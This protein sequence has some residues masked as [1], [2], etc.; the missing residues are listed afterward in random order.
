ML[1]SLELA[2]FKSFADK[3]RFEFPAGVTAVV[4]P[5]GSGKSN[6]VDAIKWVL[7]SQSPKSLRGKEMTDV[8]F[9]GSAG[10]RPLNSAEVT[11]EFENPEPPAGGRRLFDV[12]EPLVRFT[13]R[14][15]RSGEG[16]YL[17]NGRPCRLR[18]FRELMAGT[19]VGADGYSVIEQGR[20]D[21]A[22]QASPTERRAL[23]EEAAG[24]SRFRI[25][26]REASKRLERVEQN[27]ARLRDIVDEVEG[28]LKRVRSQA[29]KAQR[30]RDATQRLRE[31]RTLLGVADWRALGAEWTRLDQQ[32]RAL[33]ERRERTGRLLAEQEARLAGIGGDAPGPDRS[34]REAENHLAK[35]RE[36]IA[37][38][39]AL[40]EHERRRRDELA[41]NAARAGERLIAARRE[42]ERRV[43]VAPSEPLAAAERAAAEIAE[44]VVA[45]IKLIE[46]LGGRVHGL[47]EALSAEKR[48][49]DQRRAAEVDLRSEEQRVA[50]RIE[51]ARHAIAEIET[52][53]VASEESAREAAAGHATAAAACD[54]ATDRLQELEEAHRQTQRRLA[55]LRKG[56]AN[57]QKQLVTRQQQHVALQHRLESLLAESRRIEMLSHGVATLVASPRA[58]ASPEVLGLVADLLHVD[59]D[60][61]PLVEA[62]LGARTGNVVIDSG[63]KLLAAIEQTSETMPVRATFERL[64]SVTPSAAIDRVDLSG[65]PGVMGRADDFVE[66]DERFGTLVARLLGRTWFVDTLATAARLAKGAGRGL[67]F[68][69]QRGE[70]LAADGAVAIGPRE[71]ADGS[72]GRRRLIEKLTAE[73]AESAEAIAAAAERV[74]ALERLTHEAERGL[75]DLAAMLDSQRGTLSDSVRSAA[76]LEERVRQ[77]LASAAEQRSA[78][79][80]RRTALEGL[81]RRKGD[82]DERRERLESDAGERGDRVGELGGMLTQAEADLAA[83]RGRHAERQ[84][85]AERQSQLVATLRSQLAR[86]SD[87]SPGEPSGLSVAEADLAEA[88]AGVERSDLALLAASA[89]LAALAIELEGWSEKRQSA[90]VADLATRDVRRDVAAALGA[91]REESQ[92]LAATSAQV[93]LRRQQVQLERRTLADRL[94]DDNIDLAEAAA[95]A[96]PGVEQAIDREA[97]RAEVDSLRAELHGVGPVN[98]ESLEELDEL[99]TRF[100][101]LSGKHADL[102]QAKADLVRLTT[103]INAE[104]RELYLASFEQ[105]RSHF[106]EMFRRLFGGGEADLVVVRDPDAPAT[107]DPLEGGV[108]IVACPPGKEL[109]NLSLLSGGEKTMT[110]VAL[111]LSLFRNNPSPFCVLDEVD[112]ALDEANIGRFSKV[113]T[114]FLGSTQFLVITHSKRTMTGANTMYGVT[115]QESGVSKQVSVR[116]EDVT[117]DGHIRSIGPGERNA[118]DATTRR[119]A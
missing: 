76:A 34:L 89:R 10:R 92:Q 71:A 53:A 103:R 56:L 49:R 46:N 80:Q 117:E 67:S 35:V 99:E 110:C 5:N 107:E 27:L 6:V 54:A 3:T 115:M 91:L 9:N 7:G 77:A 113:L 63:D 118:A 51:A 98:L 85:A 73:V 1:K 81:R 94:R 21:G 60:M 90:L 23:F 108:E 65:E 25:K 22:L 58:G 119:A 109:R 40:V 41:V 17:V 101:E 14:V 39:E 72:L 105:V 28:R 18:D 96:A 88:R 15:Y 79:E 68:V 29:G 84:A 114:E 74:E 33:A 106:R 50:E 104:S 4:G 97:L 59:I 70:L 43:R 11:L 87:A 31:V 37:R 75:T 95:K 102:S 44:T 13:R 47:R 100:A 32:H 12:G 2:G 82:L 57:D 48:A 86:E 19:G 116:F 36:R 55:E 62:A 24:I 26:R 20:V 30:Y 66:A 38:E 42:A 93:E 16:E 45:G 83:E 52:R 64:D 78:L 112:A 8:I 111:L 61:A 69:T